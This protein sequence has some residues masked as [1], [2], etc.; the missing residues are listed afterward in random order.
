MDKQLLRN[1]LHIKFWTLKTH[2]AMCL[3][4][5]A[6]AVCKLVLF[7]KPFIPTIQ[8]KVNEQGARI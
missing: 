3:L 5:H 8:T 6:D 1:Y 7:I 2:V 4:A